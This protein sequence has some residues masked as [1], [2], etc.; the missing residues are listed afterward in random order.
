MFDQGTAEFQAIV[1]HRVREDVEFPKAARRA[2]HLR[3][4]AMATSTGVTGQAARRP[5]A[6]L[7][8]ALRLPAWRIWGQ[9]R[10]S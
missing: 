9:A 2:Q 6:R 10:V 4:L 1:Q 5:L 7:A 3:E 8:L